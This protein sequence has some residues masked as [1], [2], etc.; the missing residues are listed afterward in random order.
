MAQT[1]QQMD[2]GS[3]VSAAPCPFARAAVAGALR[4]ADALVFPLHKSVVLQYGLGDDGQREL[5]LYYGRQVICFDDPETFAFGEALARHPQ[6]LA[7]DALAWQPSLG[8]ARI[9][10]LLERLIEADVLWRPADPRMGTLPKI[11]PGL[12][13]SPLPPAPAP[14][15]R[16][17]DECEQIMSELG[18]RPIEL[19][20]LELV[21]PIFRVAHMAMD[22]EG[23]QVGEANVFPKALRVEVETRWQTCLFEGSRHQSDLPM[24]VTALKAMRAWWPQMMVVLRHVREAYLARFPEA[25]DGWTVGHVE[26]MATAVLALPT[27]QLM[28][29]DRPVPNGALHP[30]LSCLFRVTDGLRMTMHQMLFVP[31]GEPTRAPDSPVDA[32]EIHDYAERNHSFHSE[33]GV[34]AGPRAMVEEFLATIL[35]GTASADG[36]PVALDGEVA[37]AL[38]EIPA[39]MDYGLLGLKAYAATFSLWPAMTRAYEAIAQAVSACAGGGAGA[40][41]DLDARFQAHIQAVRQ[42]TYI[43]NEEWRVNRETVYADMY[44]QCVRGLTGDLP[45][46]TLPDRLAPSRSAGAS[47][48]GRDLNALLTQ[49]LGPETPAPAVRDL[50]N[51]I[52]DFLLRT[53]AVLRLG[54]EAQREINHHLGRSQPLL[55]FSGRDI[56]VHNILQGVAQRR[57]PYLLDELEA[58]FGLVLE[59]DG[60]SLSVA[61]VQTD[62]HPNQRNSSGAVPVV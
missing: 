37:D 21:V 27:W 5:Q 19:G 33:H 40:A 12:R 14:A 8:W 36:F 11:A 9:A 25:R 62:T 49:R 44:A 39:A 61:S 7:G 18:G 16:T 43:A 28:R 22:G 10:E 47:A 17:W 59:V 23:R 46:R 54:G 57:L 32:A 60:E 51:A 52:L 29:K 20:H 42:A 55:R 26:R 58:A 13:S 34:C 15:P 53:Q 38:S 48:A 6:F 50:T 4:P 56:E 41:V 3:A 1:G 30:A 35:H 45:N 2:S 31:F 24:N